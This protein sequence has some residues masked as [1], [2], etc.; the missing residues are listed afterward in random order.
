MAYD[1]AL[2]DELRTLLA[3]QEDVTERRMFGGLAFLLNGHMAVAAA[4]A[5]G[6]LVRV[7]PAD[8]D[9]FQALP[10]VSAMEMRGRTM[11]GWLQ[12]APDALTGPDD[13]AGWVERGVGYVRTL[14][15]K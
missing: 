2:A 14:P 13:V 5:G 15:P 4:H 8:G 6:L 11:R 10:H 3:T 12:V 1:Q 9:R 7:D